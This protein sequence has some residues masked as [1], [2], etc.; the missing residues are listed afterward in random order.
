MKKVFVS[1][2]I[3]FFSTLSY[4]GEALAQ[5]EAGAEGEGIGQSVVDILKDVLL[6]NP[7]RIMELDE[8]TGRL[9]IQ[10]TPSNH[11]MIDQI[12]KALD[13]EPSQIDI[14]TRFVEL[15]LTDSDEFGFNWG[16]TFVWYDWVGPTDVPGGRD[17]K[18]RFRGID[19]A[20][21]TLG[22]LITFSTATT[23]GLDLSIA[24]LNT[25]QLDLFLHALE[26]AD[27]ANLLSSPKITTI[28]GQLANIQITTT[29]PYVEDVDI[30]VE[31]Y[32]SGG[33]TF[34]LTRYD[35]KM[36]ETVLGI[37]LEVKPT[38]G[39]AGII[40]LE[41]H[42]EVEVLADRLSIFT[43]SGQSDLGWPVVDTRSCQTTVQVKSGET[44]V[45]G[46]LMDDDYK[47]YD[48]K[49]PVLGDIP[50]LGNL[51]KNKYTVRIKKNLLI[52]VTATL[53]NP[54]GEVA[55]AGY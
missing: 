50:L 1:L 26:R 31:Q 32:E 46:G 15:K 16:S 36:N 51:F 6:P 12:I 35:W 38:V 4:Q 5:E 19:P 9:F 17:Y 30:T 22:N 8:K 11:K 13:K 40:T 37:K 29:T 49:V 41:L 3:I 54:S 48:R 20:T 10:D 44:V 7:K 21:Q 14:E 53:V 25:N 39:E 18:W 27:K 34:F 43:S 33:T 2:I 23:G 24:K 42:P 28:G 52:F 47:V 45:M 55:K